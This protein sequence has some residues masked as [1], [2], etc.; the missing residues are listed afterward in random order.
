[1]T[2]RHASRV[3]ID[4]T[5]HDHVFPAMVDSDQRW[6]GWAIPSFDLD[7]C[8]RIAAMVNTPD[9]DSMVVTFDGDTVVVTTNDGDE[10]WVDRLD[11]D[12]DGL[13]GLGAMSW[14]WQEL[15]EGAP[16]DDAE[17]DAWL[18]VRAERGTV[19]AEAS[20]AANARRI[21]EG[22]PYDADARRV[23]TEAGNA[24]V[25]LYDMAVAFGG[26]FHPDTAPNFYTDYPEG[27][28]PVR[29]D[30]VLREALD[31]DVDVYAVAVKAV[32]R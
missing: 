8:R 23:L 15:P 11:P 5:T 29:V 20:N 13:Y 32:T 6:N 28:S 14:T 26:G 19:Y 18:G 25:A 12:A 4:A 17:L 9:D 30:K 1:M 10:S 22:R 3:E 31:A 16:T 21:A 2:T 7:T 27:Y 24:A